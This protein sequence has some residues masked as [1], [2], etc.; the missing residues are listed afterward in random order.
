MRKILL[1]AGMAMTVLI[2]TTVWLAAAE[3]V[4]LKCGTKECN[5]AQE[6]LWGPSMTT[7]VI[8]GYCAQCKKVVEIRWNVPMQDG[9]RVAVPSPAPLGTV[10]DAEHGVSLNLYPCP[11]C[12]GPFIP[13]SPDREKVRYC[14]KCGESSL[15]VEGLGGFKD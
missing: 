8:T 1:I 11:T 5:F 13:F 7:N 3:Q 15:T 10:W 2:L 9:K 4:R 14:P 12:K 6:T